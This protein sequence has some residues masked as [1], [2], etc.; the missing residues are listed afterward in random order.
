MGQTLQG[1]LFVTLPASLGT[2]GPLP[3]LPARTRQVGARPCAGW[4]HFLGTL[5]SWLPIKVSALH[6]SSLPTLTTGLG[7]LAPLLNDPLRESGDGVERFLLLLLDEIG[8]LN[9]RSEGMAHRQDLD[10]EGL[11]EWT[12][13]AN[14]L[15]GRRGAAVS[16]DGTFVAYV[17]LQCGQGEVAIQDVGAICS[18][19]SQIAPVISS[20]PLVP[21]FH[22]N[23]GGSGWNCDNVMVARS[24]GKRKH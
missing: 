18:P 22:F 10:G 15:Q 17:L 21:L 16:Q 4:F 3:Q 13:A 9:L 14:S 23:I 11:L 8:I 24:A 7:T 12:K 5:R 19:D 2:R 6:Q 20:S 1:S